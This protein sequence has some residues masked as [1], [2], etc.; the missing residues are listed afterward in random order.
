VLDAFDSDRALC[1]HQAKDR[2][3]EINISVVIKLRR[4]R[5][6][7]TCVSHQKGVCGRLS[8]F[9][10]DGQQAQGAKMKTLKR[11]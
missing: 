10:L 11:E 7:E 5:L 4:S 3:Q 6:P 9:L 1:W 8:G 2:R